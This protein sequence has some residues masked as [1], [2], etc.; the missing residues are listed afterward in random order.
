MERSWVEERRRTK[1]IPRF[2]D[3]RSCLKLV[4]A[5]L[6]RASRRWMRVRMTELQWA[7]LEQL[8]RE[9]GQSPP[10]SS[11]SDTLKIAA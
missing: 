1:V 3:E 11:G 6:I 10:P 7:Q 2:R 8:R 4:F 9:L 5:T